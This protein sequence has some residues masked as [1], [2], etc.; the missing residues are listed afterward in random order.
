MRFVFC[1][2]DS[3]HFI[4]HSNSFVTIALTKMKKIFPSKF[5]N[6]SS[7]RS[8]TF[9]IYVLT[10]MIYFL[11]SIVSHGNAC[12]AMLYPREQPRFLVLRELV[13][14]YVYFEHDRSTL[15][16]M[17]FYICLQSLYKSTPSWFY[18][19]GILYDIFL[20]KISFATCTWKYR[21]PSL[22]CK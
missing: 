10:T 4:F 17:I 14:Q 12:Y 3:T 22:L 6:I 1:A 20:L 21:F 15:F 16:T 5:H 19:H 7:S 9:C 2:S 13:F 18:S 8:P 11:A